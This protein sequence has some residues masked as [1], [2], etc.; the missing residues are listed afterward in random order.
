MLTNE[1]NKIQMKYED[2]LRENKLNELDYVNKFDSFHEKFK[3]IKD[4][5]KLN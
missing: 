3:Q 1:M 2:S 4:D 5:K